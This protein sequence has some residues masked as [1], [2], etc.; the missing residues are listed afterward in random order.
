MKKQTGESYENE[1]VEFLWKIWEIY[2]DNTNRTAFN[3]FE[4]KQS[5]KQKYFF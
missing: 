2:I 1:K 5:N 3:I 4:L